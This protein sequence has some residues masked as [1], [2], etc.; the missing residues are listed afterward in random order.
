[1]E[2][3]KLVRPT[4][5]YQEQAYEYVNEFVKYN[6]QI[7]GISSLDKYMG[8]YDEWLSKVEFNRNMIPGTVP[9]RVPSEIFFL[10]RETDNKLLGTIDIRLMLNEYLLN[11]GGHIGYGVRPTERRKGYNSYQLYLAL[12]FC[13]EK[14]IEK[15][16]ITCNKE[17]IGSAKS[18]MKAGGVL[19]NEVIE[20]SGQE[21][22]RYW[23]E[24]EPSVKKLS[25]KYNK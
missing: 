21:M 8:N 22:Q 25:K 23:I 2:G 19:E 3:L 17:N 20:P 24:V 15:V 13:L 11:Y 7:H 14:G 6:S 5:E 10:V 16:L 12:K 18:I 1:M 9:G 4:K